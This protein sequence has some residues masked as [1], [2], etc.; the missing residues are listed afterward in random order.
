MG[1]Q[2]SKGLIAG[3][4]LVLL[5]V[6][7]ETAKA[8]ESNRQMVIR[9]HSGGSAMVD[10]VRPAGTRTDEKADEGRA[11]LK[12]EVAELD[13]TVES[14]KRTRVYQSRSG[15]SQMSQTLPVGKEK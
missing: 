8:E 10:T 2:M 4:F 7:L 3:L 9:S 13:T 14:A 11:M 6:Q 5:G 15:G 1:H 12:P